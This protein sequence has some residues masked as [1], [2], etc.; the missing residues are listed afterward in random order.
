MAK[1]YR[2]TIPY[3]FCGL[4]D[5]TLACRKNKFAGANLKKKTQ[6]DISPYLSKLPQ[7]KNPVKI[8]FLWQEKDK[9]RDP[10][11]VSFAQKFILDEMVKLQKIPND[12]GRWIRGL[13]HSFIYGDSYQVQLTI[14]EDNNDTEGTTHSRDEKVGRGHRKNPVGASEKGLRKTAEKD[15]KR[16]KRV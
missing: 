16:T 15:A 11:N 6:A 4:N 8:L 12:T 7:V 3:K 10:D 5:Y 14:I 1:I 2:V 13:Y 9:R